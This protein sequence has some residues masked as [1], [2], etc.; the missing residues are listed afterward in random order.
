MS[1][2]NFEIVSPPK[3]DWDSTMINRQRKTFIRA[4]E[5][6]EDKVWDKVGKIFLEKEQQEHFKF[7]RFFSSK[8]AGLYFKN[9]PSEI[10]TQFKGT[11]WSQEDAFYRVKEMKEYL[12][13]NGVG[14]K[15]TTLHICVDYKYSTLLPFKKLPFQGFSKGTEEIPIRRKLNGNN[16]QYKIFNSVFELTFYDKS[17]EI[18]D[19]KKESLYP[20]QYTDEQIYRMELKLKKHVDIDFN[21][22]ELEIT[23]KKLQAFYLKHEPERQNA[24][25]RKLFFMEELKNDEN[26]AD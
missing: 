20:K 2:K 24:I 15:T 8:K 1:L 11:F 6:F 16:K 21:L 14:F 19:N 12:F 13:E 18:R 10:Y 5:E 3:I 26:T 22:T 17:Q 7:A 4:N 25:L 9:D 23:K